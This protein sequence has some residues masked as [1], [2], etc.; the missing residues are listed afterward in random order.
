[1]RI[2]RADPDDQTGKRRRHFE[3]SIDSPFTILNCRATQANTALPEYCDQ[4]QVPVQRPQMSC[5]CPDAHAIDGSPSNSSAHLALVEQDLAT[6]GSSRLRVNSTNSSANSSALP[7]MPRAAHVHDSPRVSGALSRP[8]QSDRRSED[9]GSHPP[10]QPTSPGLF[11]RERPIHLLRHPS[12]NP[13]AF[14]ADEPPPPVPAGLLTPPPNYDLIVGTPSVDGLADYFTRLA[15]YE[16]PGQ[17]GPSQIDHLDT[18]ADADIDPLSPGTDTGSEEATPTNEAD[19]FSTIGVAVPVA[20]LDDDHDDSSDSGDDDPA[21]PHRRGRVN[22]ANPRTPGG[23]LVPSRSLEIVRP[24]MRLDM[25]G[26]VR[27]PGYED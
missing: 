1:M 6:P 16:G 13:P 5:G 25:T 9:P 27:R 18:H 26:V 15:D 24:V 20:P 22:V 23:R 12:F 17:Q 2:S 4:G 11:E 10:S 14:D 7:G 8:S 3:I 19:P 21:R